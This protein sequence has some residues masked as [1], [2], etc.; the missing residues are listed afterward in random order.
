[1]PRIQHLLMY[2]FSMEPTLPFCSCVF[3]LL[4]SPEAQRSSSHLHKYCDPK[5]TPHTWSTSC[6]WVQTGC[7]QRSRTSCLAQHPS[8]RR[9]LTCT[10]KQPRRQKHS[11]VRVKRRMCE[12]VFK[13][14]S[15][16]GE[17]GYR[18]VCMSEGDEQRINCMFMEVSSRGSSAPRVQQ[19]SHDTT[20]SNDR[21]FGEEFFL[22]SA[23]GPQTDSPLVSSTLMSINYLLRYVLLG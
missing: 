17:G 9:A 21:N 11:G 19:E 18:E 1:M 13:L 23:S 5:Y 15:V 16:V 4:L 20:R 14:I 3:W 12:I 6:S 2:T 7:N 10:N 22:L 8:D